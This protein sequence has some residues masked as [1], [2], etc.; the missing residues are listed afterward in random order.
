MKTAEMLLQFLDRVKNFLRTIN[1]YIDVAIEYM[2][3]ARQWIEK[4]LDAVENGL[5]SL[6]D[7]LHKH[8]LRANEEHMFV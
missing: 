8:D 5:K 7:K 4:V 3:V 1:S 6:A 2:G